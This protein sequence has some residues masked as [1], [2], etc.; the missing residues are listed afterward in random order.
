MPKMC[1]T[2]HFNSNFSLNFH[3]GENLDNLRPT[4]THVLIQ[5]YV[6]N[7]FMLV[8]STKHSRTCFQVISLWASL[9]SFHGLTTVTK[10]WATKF[11]RRELLNRVY[12]KC[13]IFAEELITFV[14][15]VESMLPLFSTS[16]MQLT[17]RVFK[18][19]FSANMY[20]Q[21]LSS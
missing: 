20:S 17:E 15:Y 4:P 13:N 18:H 10:F 7:P 21:V 12:S 9:G 19:I 16:S 2:S 14:N 1:Y 6:Q 8:D 11:S 3:V 5:S